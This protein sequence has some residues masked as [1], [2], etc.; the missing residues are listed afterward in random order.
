MR[1]F[2]IEQAP[3]SQLKNFYTESHR[4]STVDKTSKK[5]VVRVYPMIMNQQLMLNVDIAHNP[6]IRK[7]LKKPIPGMKIAGPKGT[8]QE[9][10]G[11]DIQFF[12]SKNELIRKVKSL[13]AEGFIITNEKE[14]IKQ[15]DS[16]TLKKA[17]K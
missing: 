16:L 15:A 3:I 12:S 13:K 10:S 17:T 1:K 5:P 7:I 14:L 11:L 9:T 6:A 2:A 4:M 8:F